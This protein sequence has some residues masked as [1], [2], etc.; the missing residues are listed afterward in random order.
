MLI[1]LAMPVIQVVLF[2]FALTTEVRNVQVAV[3][4]GARDALSRQMI[5]QLAVS[6]HFRVFEIERQE[7]IEPLFRRGEAS[8][9]VIFEGYLEEEVVRGEGAV[10]QLV[11]D[12]SEPNQAVSWVNYAGGI[13]GSAAQ[14]G[15][16][17]GIRPVVRMLYNPQMKSAYNFVPGVM[18]LILMLICAMMTSVAIVREKEVGTMEALLVSPIGAGAITLAKMV[19]Y[20]CLSV[21][22][23]ATIMLLSV[24]VLGVPVAGNWGVLVGFSLLFIGVGLALGLLISVMVRTQVAAI[25]VS[26]MGLMMPT[27]ILSGMIFP[28]E[29]MPPILQGLSAVLPVRWYIAGVKKLMVQGVEGVYVLREMGIL[30]GM[31][32]VLLA[33]SFKKFNRRLT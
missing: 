30:A 29:S 25:L 7:E 10:V 16:Q 14:M 4:D 13:M 26:G 33:V 1:L 2:G 31:L 17:G 9:A 3:L 22:N 5:R 20:F 19:P 18:G 21:V 15:A 24:F 8:M 32:L 11:V 27:M 6:E 28:V 12:A 23:L